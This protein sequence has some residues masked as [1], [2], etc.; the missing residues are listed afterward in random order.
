M[1]KDE[2]V[3]VDIALLPNFQGQG[4]GATLLKELQQKAK[5][6]YHYDLV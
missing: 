5:L 1:T 6:A 3:L 2:M 4:I